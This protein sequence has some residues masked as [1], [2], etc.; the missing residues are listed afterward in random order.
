ML[1]RSILIA[2][3]VVALSGAAGFCDDADVYV[4]GASC[5]IGVSLV[6]QAGIP[7]LLV[8]FFVHLAAVPSTWKL[9]VLLT[10]PAL[11]GFIGA[12]FLYAAFRASD[13]F[14]ITQFLVGLFML[15]LGLAPVLLGLRWSKSRSDRNSRAEGILAQCVAIIFGF[16]VALLIWFQWI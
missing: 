7:L 11:F 12:A 2:L 4:I 3:A 9:M 5:P 10:W 15:V 16:A 6:L 13:Q 1:F 14:L 8:C